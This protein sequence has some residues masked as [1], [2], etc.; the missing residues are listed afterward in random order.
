MPPSQDTYLFAHNEAGLLLWFGDVEVC[1]FS[2]PV[3]H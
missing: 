1:Q 2:M 3:F